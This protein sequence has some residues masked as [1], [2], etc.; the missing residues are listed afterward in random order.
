MLVYYWCKKAHL[1]ESYLYAYFTMILVMKHVKF[2]K[3][4]FKFEESYPHKF[5]LIQK[6]HIK[7]G[8]DFLDALMGNLSQCYFEEDA[9]PGNYLETI[10]RQNDLAEILLALFIL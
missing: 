9:V 2:N 6:Y 1:S 7:P 4:I 3:K 5:D 10:F 8:S